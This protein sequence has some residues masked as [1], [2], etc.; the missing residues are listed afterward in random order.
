[1]RSAPLTAGTL[2]TPVDLEHLCGAGPCKALSMYRSNARLRVTILSSVGHTEEGEGHCVQVSTRA[3]RDGL[4]QGTAAVKRVALA[5]D[6]GPNSAEYLQ[7][8]T[9]QAQKPPFPCLT[10]YKSPPIGLL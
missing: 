7:E 6:F 8:D 3:E 9:G 1:M 10:I 4:S 5:Y 2:S